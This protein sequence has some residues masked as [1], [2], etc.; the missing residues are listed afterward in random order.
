MKVERGGE[1]RHA[2]RRVRIIAELPCAAIERVHELSCAGENAD[3]HAASKNLPIGG[4]IRANIEQRLAAT[5]MNTEPGDNFIED[6]RSTGVLSNLSNLA[7]KFARLEVGMATLDWLDKN[8]R[9]LACMGTNPLQR[10]RRAVVEYD[11]VAH[12]FARDTRGDR[13]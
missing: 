4:Q 1:E 2:D 9:E 3:G 8:R 12:A 5:R 6:Q 7:Q 13:Q 10:F 11:N